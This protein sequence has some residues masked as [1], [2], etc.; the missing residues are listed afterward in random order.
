[1][2]KSTSYA[3]GPYTV[4]LSHPDK[5]LFPEAKLSKKDVANYYQNLASPFLRHAKDRPLAMHR[6]PEG[7]QEK[8]FFQKEVPNYFPDWVSRCTVSR[9][10]ADAIPMLVADKQA[11][12]AY[13][14]QQ[15]SIAQHLFLSRCDALKQPDKL[16]FD[17]DPAEDGFDLALQAARQLHKH[18]HDKYNLKSFVMTTGSSGLHVLVPLQKG[19]SYKQVRDFAQKLAAELA[20]SHPK[21]FTTEQRKAKRKGRLFL[22]VLQNSYGQHSIAPYSLRALPHAPVATPLHWEELDDLPQQSQSYHFFNIEERL[23]KTGDPWANLY[24]YAQR[25]P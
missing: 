18:L 16:L 23:A 19:P 9:K 2:T 15:A 5:L 4:K 7:I 14:A 24:Q 22:D 8:D 20:E 17:L 25:L 3:F 21:A 1:M 13:L 11:T 12:L 10:S 6:F